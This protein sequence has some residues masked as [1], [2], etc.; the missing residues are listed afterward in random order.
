MTRQDLGDQLGGEG[1]P[2][3]HWPLSF[4]ASTSAISWK[5]SHLQ[6]RRSAASLDRQSSISEEEVELQGLGSPLPGLAA[7]LSGLLRDKKGSVKLPSAHRPGVGGKNADVLA[8]SLRPLCF[9]VPQPHS[10]APSGQHSLHW[11]LTPPPPLP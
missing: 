9:R 11:A 7:A 2:T 8:P 10:L 4:P 5:M 6:L 1:Q 3:R